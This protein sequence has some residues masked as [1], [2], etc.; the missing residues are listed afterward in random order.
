MRY[1]WMMILAVLALGL[2]VGGALTS[3]AQD[4][5]ADVG[6]RVGDADDLPDHRL[7]VVGGGLIIPYLTLPS[8]IVIRMKVVLR[9]PTKLALSSAT[10]RS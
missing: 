3:R 9:F 7:G 6:G 4:A 8:R 2:Y 5:D 10:S 1:R